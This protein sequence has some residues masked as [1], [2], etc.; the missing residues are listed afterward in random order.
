MLYQVIRFLFLIR[1]SV[2]VCLDY[3]ADG[4]LYLNGPTGGRA[5]GDVMLLGGYELD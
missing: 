1:H 5:K 2:L 3:L 4:E